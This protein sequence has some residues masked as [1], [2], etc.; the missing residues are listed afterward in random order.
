LNGSGVL[1]INYSNL[2][3]LDSILKK[4]DKSD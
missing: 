3:Q 2:D 4:I 1:K